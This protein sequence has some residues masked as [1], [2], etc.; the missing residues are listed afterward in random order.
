MFFGC[1]FFCFFFVGGV[2]AVLS[3]VVFCCFV[4]FFVCLFVILFYF[5]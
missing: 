3:F 1:V 4:V 2:D 5:I